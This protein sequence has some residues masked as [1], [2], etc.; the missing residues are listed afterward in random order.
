MTTQ[1][2]PTINSEISFEQIATVIG[3]HEVQ[4]TPNAGLSFLRINYN[5]EDDN[6]RPLPVGSWTV[7]TENGPVFAKEIDFQVFLQRYQYTHWDEEA[8]EMANK[9]ILA[10]NLF[11]QMEVPDML[12]TMRCGSVPYAKREGLSGEQALKQKS[13]RC[14]RMLFGKVTFIDAVDV[15]GNKVEASNIPCLWRARG[16]NFMTISDAM[17]SLSAQKKPFLFYT[18]RSGLEKKKNGG[19]IYYVSNFKVQEGPLSF[20]ADDNDL[21]KAFCDY[22]DNENTQVM[23]AHDKALMKKANSSTPGEPEIIDVDDALNDDLTDIGK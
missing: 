17:D 2:L 4:N 8:E 5:S 11:P 7:N 20:E 6:E 22:V 10:Q 21:L 19:V 16:S 18:L 12:G 14:F 1:T 9:S 3:Q 15:D 13:I 23:K